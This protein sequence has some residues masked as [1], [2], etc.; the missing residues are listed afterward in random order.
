[1]SMETIFHGCKLPIGEH[2]KLISKVFAEAVIK[3]RIRYA[4]V[5]EHDK[6]W[7]R[8]V[9]SSW[10]LLGASNDRSMLVFSNEIFAFSAKSIIQFVF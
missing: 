10:S 1:M 7:N 4:Y 5:C 3:V 2:N 8:N 9:C 6:Y